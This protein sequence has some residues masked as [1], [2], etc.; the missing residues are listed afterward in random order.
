MR[1]F[2]TVPGSRAEG[3]AAL[4]GALG[5][6]GAAEGVARRRRRRRAAAVRGRR[7]GRG[8]HA[9]PRPPAGVDAPPSGLAHVLVYGDR[10]WATLQA[11]LYDDDGATVAA[12][13]PPAWRSWMAERFPARD[14]AA[15]AG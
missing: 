3:W 14:A 10:G 2:G 11:C 1:A 4:A 7:A 12:R 13:E 9:A 5:L 15:A 8:R 6:A